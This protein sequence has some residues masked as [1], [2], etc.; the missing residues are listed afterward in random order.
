MK[1][2]YF[3]IVI[4]FIFFISSCDSDKYLDLYPLTSITEGNFYNSELELQQGLNDVYRQLGRIYNAHG[5]VDLYGEQASDN[6]YIFIKGGGDNYTE[7]INDFWILTENSRI[8]TAWDVCYNAIHICNTIIFQLDNTTLEMDANLKSRMKAEAIL[9]RSLIYF[10]MV[11]VWGD[12]P[13]VLEPITPLEAYDFLRENT[14]TIYEN[15]ISDLNIAKTNLPESYTG[16]D[17]GRVTRFGAAGILAKIYLTRGNNQA[18]RSELEFIINSNRF[19]LDSNNDGAVN[20]EDYLHLFDP[21]TKNSKSSILE[22]QYLAGVNA[23]NSNHQTAYTP[24]HWAFNLGDIGGPTSTFRGEGINTPTAD[25]ANE[26]ED[27]DPRKDATFISGYTD[28]ST[29]EFIDYPWTVKYFDPNWTNPGSNVPIIRYADILLM[30]SEVTG[31]AIH[32]NMVRERAGLPSF[33]SGEYP[34]NL[35]PT[36]ERAIEHERRVE[37]AFEFHRFFDLVRTGR[38]VEVM[39]AKGYSIN[40]N[41][42]LFPIPQNAIDVNPELTQ[43]PG[44]N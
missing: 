38:A 28:L 33:G 39:Q 31:E 37:F 16:S 20:S 13:L 9:I 6:T 21:V 34:S 42:L 12:V 29:N 32:L 41:K 22:V 24:F 2:I 26:F 4:I 40:E 3:Y 1:T 14:N 17:I 11:R 30:Y 36:L 18:A 5:V 43:N 44:Y 7:Q 19:S 35:Y 27:G 10:N 15:I 23:H 8:A 25:L